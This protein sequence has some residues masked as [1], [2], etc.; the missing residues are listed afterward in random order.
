M[1]CKSS[2]KKRP[3]LASTALLVVPAVQKVV[4]AGADAIA[5]SKM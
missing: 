4:V 3:V 2:A 1:P 5:H